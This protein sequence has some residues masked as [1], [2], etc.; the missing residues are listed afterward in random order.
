MLFLYIRFYVLIADHFYS[1]FVYIRNLDIYSLQNKCEFHTHSF[2]QEEV[3][4][5]VVYLVL[6]IFSS[7]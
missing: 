7:Y 3:S 4:F 1:A 2:W 6:L 5:N